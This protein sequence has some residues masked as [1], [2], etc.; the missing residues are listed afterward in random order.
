MDKGTFCFFVSSSVFSL[1]FQKLPCSMDT[2]TDLMLY[3][4][5]LTGNGTTHQDLVL[6]LK[7][8][9]TWWK[10]QKISWGKYAEESHCVQSGY[11]FKY[12]IQVLGALKESIVSWG[13]GWVGQS[14]RGQW[15]LHRRRQTFQEYIRFGKVEMT[16][17]IF[18]PR[19]FPIAFKK[20]SSLSHLNIQRQ[21]NISF[22]QTSLFNYCPF[23]FPLF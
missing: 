7:K 17:H 12:Q 1:Y 8:S 22:D 2:I 14:R 18:S 10:R 16:R 19:N 21:S 5:H 9:T 13:R 15:I 6:P 3:F 11:I 20:G 23:S 4:N